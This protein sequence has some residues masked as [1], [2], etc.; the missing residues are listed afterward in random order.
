ML[1]GRESSFQTAGEN[2]EVGKD[3]RSSPE[4]LSVPE[5]NEGIWGFLLKSARINTVHLSAMVS[6]FRIFSPLVISL[7][8][9]SCIKHSNCININDDAIN[10]WKRKDRMNEARRNLLCFSPLLVQQNFSIKRNIFHVL[11]KSLNIFSGCHHLSQKLDI[12]N[13]MCVNT[14]EIS[15]LV[16]FSCCW[17]T[18][19][20]AQMNNKL[21]K[22]TKIH[23]LYLFN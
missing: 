17:L 18:S 14:R 23:Q 16:Y 6:V 1:M 11:V 12:L 19:L 22:K 20:K 3:K 9:C 8:S 10:Q 13:Y 7:G 2:T 15:R 21:Q 5:E 4:P